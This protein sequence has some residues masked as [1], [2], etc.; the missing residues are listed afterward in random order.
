MVSAGPYDNYTGPVLTKA[1]LGDADISAQI[2]A[3]YGVGRNW[4]G[5]LW[6]FADFLTGADG[7][8]D[9]LYGAPA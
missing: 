1:T 8:E 4:Q 5:R 3:M 2:Q 9:I 6:R 7:G